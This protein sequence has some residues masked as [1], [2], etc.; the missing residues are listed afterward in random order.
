MSETGMKCNSQ[1]FQGSGLINAVD[2]ISVIA[3]VTM[4]LHNYSIE[5]G[6]VPDWK[7]YSLDSNGLL[8]IAQ[9]EYYKRE[10]LIS[11]NT[12]NFRV[13]S[14]NPF[15]TENFDILTHLSPRTHY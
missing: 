15:S 3:A 14:I 4:D 6:L 5:S 10:S 2:V 11:L 1:V 12:L 9:N 13:T 7:G 8:K